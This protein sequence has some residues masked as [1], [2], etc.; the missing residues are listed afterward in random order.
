MCIHVY[1]HVYNVHI[2][3]YVGT[4]IHKYILNSDMC[5]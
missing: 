1:I 2:N 4:H 3:G 5:I